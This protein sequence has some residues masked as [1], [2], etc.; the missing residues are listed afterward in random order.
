V[1]PRVYNREMV[2]QLLLGV[3]VLLALPVPPTGDK[4]KLREAMG[5]T[6]LAGPWI[7][8]DLAAGIAEAGRTGKALMVVLRC[9][10]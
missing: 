4:E 10:P 2:K 8:D 1:S 3:A 6:A 7:Y 9:V 5:D